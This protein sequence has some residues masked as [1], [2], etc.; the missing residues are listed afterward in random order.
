MMENG[1][2]TAGGPRSP[3]GNNRTAHRR[4]KT[5]GKTGCHGGKAAQG[6]VEHPRRRGFAGQ[7]EALPSWQAAMTKD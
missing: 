7:E 1:A 5:N 2:R 3:R 4:G 6:G